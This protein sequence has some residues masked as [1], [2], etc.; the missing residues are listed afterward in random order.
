MM[1]QGAVRGFGVDVGAVVARGSQAG[2]HGRLPS[3]AAHVRAAVPAAALSWILVRWR[4]EDR[5]WTVPAR[6]GGQG[7]SMMVCAER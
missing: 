6:V 3:D 2:M 5:G 1:G 4:L 7:R